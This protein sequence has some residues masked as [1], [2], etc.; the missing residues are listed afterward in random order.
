MTGESASPKLTLT[1]IGIFVVVFP[2]GGRRWVEKGW[3]FAESCLQEI[4]RVHGDKVHFL[5]PGTESALVGHVGCEG[6]RAWKWLSDLETYSLTTG[7]VPLAVVALGLL[8]VVWGPWISATGVRAEGHSH[9]WE[10]LRDPFEDSL[11]DPGETFRDG[12]ER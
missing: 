4:G 12:A 9:D 8:V 5:H 6:S 3:K 10:S 11:K 1:E 2:L 7:T